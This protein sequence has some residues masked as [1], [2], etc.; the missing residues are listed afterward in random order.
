MIKLLRASAGSGKTFRLAKE[1]IVLLLTV[2]VAQGSPRRRLRAVPELTEPLRHILAITFTNKATNEMKQRIVE[3]LAALADPAEKSPD[4]LKDLMAIA[5][6][7]EEQVR[8]AAGVALRVMLNNYS[9]FQ[10][11][12]IDSFFQSV[13]R[14]FTYEANISDSYSVELDSDYVAKVGVDSTLTNLDS[15]ADAE[16]LYW[17]RRLMEEHL[18]AGKTGWNVFQKSTS[19]SSVYGTISSFTKKLESEQY[20]RHKHEIE[21]YWRDT[22]SF[23]EVY[24]GIERTIESA[25]LPAWDNLREAASRAMAAFDAKMCD[26]RLYPGR[27][28]KILAMTPSGPLPF[29]CAKELDKAA[30]MRSSGEMPWFLKATAR[31]KKGAPSAEAEALNAALSGFYLALLEYSEAYAASGAREWNIYRQTLVY[32]SLMQKAR[33]ASADYLLENNVIELAE[34]NTLL[35]KVIGDD[36]TPFIYERLGT[37][38]DNYLI[39]EFQDTSRMQWENLVPLLRESE[40]RASDNLII[41]DAKQSIYRFRNADPSLITTEVGNE[42][43]VRD[44]AESLAD[45]TNWRSRPGIV[46]FNNSFFYTLARRVDAL[47]MEKEYSVARRRTLVADLYSNIVQPH[48]PLSPD[49]DP[50]EGYIEMRFPPLPDEAEGETPASHYDELPLLIADMMERGYQQGEIA[51]LGETKKQ[52]SAVI[53]AILRYNETRPEGARPINFVSE[54]SL[55]IGDSEGVRRVLSALR[56]IARGREISEDAEAA[57]EREDDRPLRRFDIQ[58]IACAFNFLS[59]NDGAPDTPEESAR[60]LEEFLRNPDTASGVDDFI[61]TI[62]SAALPSLVEAIIA[63]YARPGEA[64][65]QAPYLAAFQD[66][67]LDYCTS[68]PADPASFLSWWDRKGSELTI[69]SPEGADAVGIMTIHKSK[70]LQFR[71]VIIPDAGITLVPSSLDEWMWVRPSDASP[72]FAALPPYIPVRTVGELDG[73]AHAEELVN[74]VESAITDKMNVA[75]VGFTRAVDELYI[76]APRK[77]REIGKTLGSLLRDVCADMERVCEGAAEEER[78][79]L[80]DA[81]TICDFSSEERITFGSRLER[82]RPRKAEMTRKDVRQLDRYFVHH[83][84]ETL[85]FTEAE[86]YSGDADDPDPRSRGNLLHE[87]LSLVETPAQLPAAA[88][89]LRIAGKITAEQQ[90]EFAAFLGERVAQGEPAEWFRPGLRVINE[91]AILQRGS[92]QYRP[93]R[94]VAHATGAACVIDYKFGAPHRRHHRQVEAYCAMLAETGLFTSVSGKLWYVTE[95]LVETVV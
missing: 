50:Q 82:A 36:E 22:P 60:R 10:I 84:P 54:E 26:A 45:N 33:E 20:K 86:V 92:A 63:N 34:T 56:M 79:W 35:A 74:A 6:A 16:A 46:R 27:I 15:H 40:S 11:S 8:Q 80:A 51:V 62:H 48:R 19:S 43:D 64:D 13:L 93:D 5:G 89:R 12:T 9:D 18:D 4:Y 29:A 38:I 28:D 3:K 41:G 85:K 47:R 59:L 23:R 67:V 75:Y 7:G 49:E 2:P 83:D 68:N 44:A 73:T 88:R 76:F 14:T 17:L 42:F 81:S 32:F 61:R 87:M 71:C 25:L 72:A 55:R 52:L 66:V 21:N 24:E 65:G 1:F 91:R 90:E 57:R 78:A 37:R 70:G 31:P 39:D 95:G 30:D 53:D 77:K 58:D 94:I 69:S